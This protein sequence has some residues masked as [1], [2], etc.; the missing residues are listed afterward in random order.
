M[1]DFFVDFIFV[2]ESVVVLLFVYLYTF[3][4]FIP[5]HRKYIYYGRYYNNK[6]TVTVKLVTA[7]CYRY[8]IMKI[9]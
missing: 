1:H 3:L 5:S 9:K 7:V 2:T 4:V 8:C 6:D